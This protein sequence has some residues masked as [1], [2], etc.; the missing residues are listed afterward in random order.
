M[1]A[2]RMNHRCWFLAGVIVFCGAQALGGGAFVPAVV[3]AVVAAMAPALVGGSMMEPQAGHDPR[4][5][6]VSERRVAWQHGHDH[7]CSGVVLAG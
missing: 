4:R 6:A 1:K 5:G 2:L 7:E 3:V